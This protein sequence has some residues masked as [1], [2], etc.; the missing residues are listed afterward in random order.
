MCGIAGIVPNNI[1]SDH[2][3][4]M[5]KML[6]VMNHRGPDY[7]NYQNFNGNVIFGHNRLAI[8][9]LSFDANRLFHHMMVTIQSYLMA[10]FIIISN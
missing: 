2:K 9:D 5:L 7:S 8:I 10:R 1:S 3:E 4:K 6:H